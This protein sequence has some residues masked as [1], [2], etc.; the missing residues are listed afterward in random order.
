MCGA[1]MP[2]PHRWRGRRPTS[3]ALASIASKHHDRAV[4]EALAVVNAPTD[5]SIVAALLG[6]D[7]DDVERSL[8]RLRGQPAGDRDRTGSVGKPGRHLDRRASG[9]R[10]GG[11][12][13]VGRRRPKAA[14]PTT[15]RGRHRRSRSGGAPATRSSP[16]TRP[17]DSPRSR[18]SPTPGPRRWHGP[19][20][21]RPSIRCEGRWR[22][23]EP[24]DDALEA[25]DRTRSR[26]RLSPPTRGRCQR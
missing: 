6:I 14:A 9:D 22:C 25:P 20:R 24:G 8:E 18:C 21:R 23:C 4:L 13:G 19:R 16:A 10:R 5:P 12:G 3:S 26:C 7:A 11:R 2:R 1:W 17:I 15:A